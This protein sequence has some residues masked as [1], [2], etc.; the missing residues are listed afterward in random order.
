[1]AQNAILRFRDLASGVVLAPE[2]YD[3]RRNQ[4]SANQSNTK[5]QL[6]GD[7]VAFERKTI[8]PKNARGDERNFIIVDTGDASEGILIG[9]K[10]PLPPDQINSHKKLVSPGDVI[11]SRLRPYLRQVAYVDEEFVSRWGSAETIQIV[12]ST[13]FYVLRAKEIEDIRFIIPF[14]LSG[15][16]QSIL[17]ASQEGGHHPRF[18]QDVLMGLQVPTGLIQNNQLISERIEHAI[19]SYRASERAIHDCIAD[20]DSQ[21]TIYDSPKQ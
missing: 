11:I 18:G 13:E 12:A 5:T 19:A 7:L 2:R 1:M 3:P 17:S 21:I 4:V 20:A 15:P 14:L 16:I 10:A 8:S 6:L 9:R